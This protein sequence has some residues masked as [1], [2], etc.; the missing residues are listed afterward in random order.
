MR[1][2]KTQC[3]PSAQHSVFLGGVICNIIATPPS[4]ICVSRVS[5]KLR[6]KRHNAV[7]PF[8]TIYSIE[9]FSVS[10]I[11]SYK[12]LAQAK[13]HFAPAPHICA[14]LRSSRQGAFCGHS[15]APNTAL[16]SPAAPLHEN[17]FI[18]NIFVIAAVQFQKSEP[19]R[20]ILLPNSGGERKLIVRRLRRAM[21]CLSIS[22]LFLSS[23]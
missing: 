17:L 9:I 16:F 19:P 11:Y 1:F 8:A 2:R 21:G 6:R 14:C 15:A 12:S 13:S 22:R 7:T 5:G 4:L 18:E 23:V 10:V 3:S 20:A